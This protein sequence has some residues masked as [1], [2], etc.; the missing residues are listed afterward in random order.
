MKPLHSTLLLLV[1]LGIRKISCCLPQTVLSHLRI[2]PYLETGSL[3]CDMNG[4][5][6]GARELGADVLMTG[7]DTGPREKRER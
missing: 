5:E 7:E 3:I 4:G 1:P 2:R 6:I